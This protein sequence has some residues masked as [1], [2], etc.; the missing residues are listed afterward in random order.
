MTTVNTQIVYLKA[1]CS[2]LLHE[3]KEYEKQGASK[4]VEMLR[5]LY[6]I[7][8]DLLE[9]AMKSLTIVTNDWLS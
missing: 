5:R 2:E 6:G 1:K 3:I 4:S 9:V 7:Y 8:E